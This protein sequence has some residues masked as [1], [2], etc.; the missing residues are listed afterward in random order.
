MSFK[1]DECDIKINECAI[2]MKCWDIEFIGIKFYGGFR[3]EI[4]VLLEIVSYDFNMKLLFRQYPY[5]I[6]KLKNENLGTK[7]FSV[8]CE[9]VG[10]KLYN[11]S[12]NKQI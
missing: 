11:I 8:S 1:Y 3:G 6:F 5:L 12:R 4:I 9:Y 2:Y 10:K 7:L